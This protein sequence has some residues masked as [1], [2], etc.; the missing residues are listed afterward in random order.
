[1][2]NKIASGSC[3][4]APN[5]YVITKVYK[6][7]YSGIYQDKIVNPVTFYLYA[8]MFWKYKLHGKR[9][10]VKSKYVYRYV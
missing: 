4:Y 10:R 2:D 6:E 5:K 3:S 1:M 9:L 8:L 7:K